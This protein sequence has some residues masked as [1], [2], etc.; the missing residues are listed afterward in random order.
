[1]PGQRDVTAEGGKKR[2]ITRESAR[3]LVTRT[4]SGAKRIAMAPGRKVK[5]KVVQ[6]R[7]RMKAV[8]WTPGKM[9]RSEEHTSE[10]QSRRNLVCRLLLE[11]KNR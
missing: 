8:Q 11:Q 4:G 1:M 9:M 2:R 10:L 3:N 7:A 6:V 5:G